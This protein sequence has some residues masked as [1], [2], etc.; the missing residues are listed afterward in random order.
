MWTSRKYPLSDIASAASKQANTT[1][2][3]RPMASDIQ[4]QKKHPAIPATPNQITRNE[5]SAGVIFSTST[6]SVV[7]PQGQPNTA[8]L[9]E[10]AGQRGDRQAARVLEQFAPRDG[11]DRRNGG[12]QIDLLR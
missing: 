4:A 7:I 10:A 8:G 9:G 2:G 12:R 6:N 11:L 3:R 1:E 5:A